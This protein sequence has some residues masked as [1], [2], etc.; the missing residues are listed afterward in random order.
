MFM[1]TDHSVF[2]GRYYLLRFFLNQ[3]I[4]NIFQFNIFVCQTKSMLGQERGV[5]V[6]TKLKMGQFVS[7]SWL[8][9]F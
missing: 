3:D 4:V 6:E 5:K 2:T 8:I 7:A 9:L 1:C